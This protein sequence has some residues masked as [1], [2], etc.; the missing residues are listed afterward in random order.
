MS[1]SKYVTLLTLLGLMAF[2][3]AAV[4]WAG[5]VWTKCH[6]SCRCQQTNSVANFKF[7]IPVDRSPDI[8]LEADQ[9]CRLYGHRACTD[10]C[11][12]TK[13]TYTYKVTSP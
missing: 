4:G 13:F 8:G 3:P 7:V 1:L 5:Q 6:I 11:N 2:A 10:A 9:A 12:G